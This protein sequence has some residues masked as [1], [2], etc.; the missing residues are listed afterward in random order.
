M[1]DVLLLDVAPLS[2]GIETA[3][4][5]MT[6]LIPRNTTIPTK[7]E[8]VPPP[9]LN[10]CK[11][12]NCPH[13][14]RAGAPHGCTLALPGCGCQVWLKNRSTLA[15]KARLRMSWRHNLVLC[16]CKLNLLHDPKLHPGLC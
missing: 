13:Q 8:Q 16:N 14:T 12:A 11:P 5:V 2:L 10:S 4:G 6:T 9:T 15:A 7:K 3:G 1:Q